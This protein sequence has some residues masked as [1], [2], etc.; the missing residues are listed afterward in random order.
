MKISGSG[1]RGRARIV[2]STITSARPRATPRATWP[3][4]T[5][6]PGL[7]ARR[8]RPAPTTPGR[9][10]WPGTTV[11]WTGGYQPKGRS[12]WGTSRRR[13]SRVS[14]SWPGPGRCTR[15][16]T[17]M[18]TTRWPGSSSSPA[19]RPLHRC[20]S[21]ECGRE[22]PAGSR[23]MPGRAGCRRCPGWSRLPRSPSTRASGSRPSSSR[24]GPRAAGCAQMCSTTRR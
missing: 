22:R 10:T 1:S 3:R 17:T 9:P 15:R 5:S 23:R 13:I 6:T 16:R 11:R 12:R 18:T 4:S 2:A 19:L 20:G 24:R 7:P 8:P 21:G 14:G